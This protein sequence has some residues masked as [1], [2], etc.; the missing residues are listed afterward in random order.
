L[1]AKTGEDV[2]SPSKR[3]G[4]LFEWKNKKEK[5]R[6]R[7]MKRRRMSLETQL[8]GVMKAIDSPKTPTQLKEGLGRR[9]VELKGKLQKKPSRGFFA[10]L[11]F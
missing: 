7:V 11:G 8:K 5:T 9:A 6:K 10:R 1:P 3:A 2:A 4:F